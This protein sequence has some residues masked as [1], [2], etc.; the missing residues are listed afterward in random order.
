MLRIE[1]SGDYGIDEFAFDGQYIVYSDCKETNIF[2]FDRTQ[3]KLKKLTKKVCAHAGV[4]KLP[5]AS[6]LAIKPAEDEK[7]E[8]LVLVTKDLTVLLV[9]LVTC[10]TQTLCSRAVIEEGL[11]EMTEYDQIVT[12]SHFNATSNRLVLSFA[13]PKY[14]CV[15]DLSSSQQNLYWRLPS[16]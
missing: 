7:N 2:K 9:D 13:N 14:F 6:V 8:Q 1:K 11:G 16:L 5:S 12:A 3:L 15:L 4:K 10:Q